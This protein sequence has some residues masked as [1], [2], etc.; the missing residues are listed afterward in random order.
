M[1]L[2]ENINVNMK[3]VKNL[4]GF[5]IRSENTLNQHIKSKHKNNN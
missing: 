4:M 5:L 1:K 3:I 2:L